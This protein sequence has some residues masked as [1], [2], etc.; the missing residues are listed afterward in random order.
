MP[1]QRVDDHDPYSRKYHNQVNLL[2]RTPKPRLPAKTL[3]L[4]NAYR[5]AL[6]ELAECRVIHASDNVYRRYETAVCK[7]RRELVIH[8][9]KP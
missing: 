3:K 1:F 6:E 9:L 5:D 2:R 4:L 7:A 8:L